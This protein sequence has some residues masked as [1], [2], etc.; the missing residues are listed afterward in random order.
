MLGMPVKLLNAIGTRILSGGGYIARSSVSCWSYLTS[1]RSG[2]NV[3]SRVLSRFASM[4]Y[5]GSTQEET[6]PIARKIGPTIRQCFRFCSFAILSSLRKLHRNSSSWP[7]DPFAEMPTMQ[8]MV[9]IKPT[10]KNIIVKKIRA[11][12]L[13]HSAVELHV[14]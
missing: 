10:S 3:F 9:K 2:Y 7:Q 11:H 14:E 5:N 1:V 6:E 12:F 8:T 4:H 13:R